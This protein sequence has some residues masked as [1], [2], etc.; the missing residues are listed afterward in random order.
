MSFLNLKMEL[1][2][3]F[4]FWV[5]DTVAQIGFMTTSDCV[6]TTQF[7]SADHCHVTNIGSN[8]MTRKEFQNI[9]LLLP[10]FV[11]LWTGRGQ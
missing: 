4:L 6:S 11:V 8:T 1:S 5:N 3:L 2:S 9:A 7:Q 10:C